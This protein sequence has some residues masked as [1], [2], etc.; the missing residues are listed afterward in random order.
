AARLLFD[1]Q[2]ADADTTATSLGLALAPAQ[3]TNY[4]T[5]W[6]EG[7]LR[8]SGLLLIHHRE[9]F[10]LL[11]TWLGSLPEDTFR[12]TVPLLRRAFTDFSL[13][14]R[15]QILALAGQ[16]AA[17]STAGS[18]ALEIDWARGRRVLPGLR[19]L[20]GVTSQL[21]VTG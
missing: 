15:R 7:F 13:P 5:G 6:I 20:L 12:E 10:G 4:A 3:P 21:E 19:Q 8:G 9:L 14:E 11:D 1:A 18:E 16:D 17:Q 2:Q